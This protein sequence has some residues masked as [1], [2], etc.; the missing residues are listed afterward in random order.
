MSATYFNIEVDT[1][2]VLMDI[3]RVQ[4]MHFVKQTQCLI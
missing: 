1:N 3:K 2:I 4:V